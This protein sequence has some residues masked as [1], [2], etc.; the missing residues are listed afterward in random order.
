MGITR[1]VSPSVRPVQDKVLLEQSSPLPLPVPPSPHHT[2]QTDSTLLSSSLRGGLVSYTEAFLCLPC[3]PA[4]KHMELHVTLLD[5]FVCK[6]KR[7]CI[8]R[9]LIIGVKRWAY[10]GCVVSTLSPQPSPLLLAFL[11]VN[12]TNLHYVLT[13]PV[14]NNTNVK[15]GRASCRERV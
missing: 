12:C 15:I 14:C 13:S 7:S 10:L 1:G 8:T 3:F 11:R 6:K 5:W 2:P 4:E 9:L